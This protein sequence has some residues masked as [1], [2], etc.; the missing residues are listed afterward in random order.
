MAAPS[1]DMTFAQFESHWNKPDFETTLKYVPIANI[2][3]K[4]DKDDDRVV[5]KGRN[6]ATR[7][8]RI[9]HVIVD[10]MKR[11]YHSYDAIE[12]A[13]ARADVEILDW[14]RPDLCPS[15]IFKIGKNLKELY[16]YW[17]GND[18]ILGAWSEAEGLPMLA[19]YGKLSK[20]FI[21]SP[22]DSP[23]LSSNISEHLKG[24][25]DRLIRNWSLVAEKRRPP[26]QERS[27][28]LDDS[29]TL[30]SGSLRLD[31]GLF[32]PCSA[33]SHISMKREV[34]GDREIAGPQIIHLAA[35][36]SLK[37][38]PADYDRPAAEMDQHRWMQCMQNFTTAFLKVR[39]RPARDAENNF[40][41]IRVALIDDGVDTTQS[42]L[43]GRD[44]LGRSFAFDDA[45]QRNYPYWISD[46]GHGT[47]M[48]R[49]IRKICPTADIYIIK[50]ATRPATQD[51]NRLTIV[52]ASVVD[53]INHA[54]DCGARVIS[55]SWSVRR[56]EDK[57]LL[58]EFDE[59]IT[60][61]VRQ[62][63]I[64]LCASGDQGKIGNDE[65]Y[66]KHADQENVI[67]IG[68]ATAMGN[69]AR[70][71]D[72]HKIDF[73]FP[74][75]KIPLRGSNPDKELGYVHEGS[76][77]ATAIAAGLATL[78]LECVQVGHFSEVTKPPRSQQ[79]IPDQDSMDSLAIRAGFASM[80]R[81]NSRYLWV[82][83]T[84]SH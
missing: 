4:P 59:A 36:T 75:H 61:A 50:V 16:L 42:S 48:A 14:R 1:T 17:G 8:K 76:S 41:S 10:D 55:M 72:E 66:P 27:A 46:S 84:F 23:D 78:I 37:S 11:N 57:E 20:I 7:V 79:S 58:K 26:S 3:F 47:I 19:Q 5:S 68:A 44:Y 56:P 12:R 21:F 2:K 38:K 34:A 24:F 54:V 33:G 40:K 25:D 74:G 30:A 39:E 60:R 53:A 69:N 31:S 6:D 35:K 62:R 70:Y 22:E 9:L 65:T 18:A 51:P 32:R 13:L 45:G 64:M 49:F 80:V 52:V 73:L 71:V 29:A 83:E 67:R 63:T 15:N 82:W 77:V 43:Q 28:I 81:S